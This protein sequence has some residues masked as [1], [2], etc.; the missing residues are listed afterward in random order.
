MDTDTFHTL[1]AYLRALVR[2]TLD[3]PKAPVKLP[4]PVAA[5][6]AAE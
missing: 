1:P 5:T 4:A 3:N 6:P 2:Y